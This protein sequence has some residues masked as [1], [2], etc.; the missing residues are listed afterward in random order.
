MLMDRQQIRFSNQTTTRLTLAIWQ[1]PAM[2]QTLVP[3]S[4]ISLEAIPGA[5]MTQTWD[6]SLSVVLGLFR[7]EPGLG[8]FTINRSKDTQTGSA[9]TIVTASGSLVLVNAGDAPNDEITMTNNSASVVNA[10][11]AQSA[12]AMFYQQDLL[13]GSN[14]VFDSER[15]M[16]AGLF[17]SMTRG[18]IINPVLLVALPMPILFPPGMSTANATATVQTSGI[19]LTITYGL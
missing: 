9:W 10:G 15:I 8:A 14:V 12:S 13:I 19:L 17:L 3:V 5:S 6:D 4:W 16:T 7:D 11:L 18:E 2:L 1:T